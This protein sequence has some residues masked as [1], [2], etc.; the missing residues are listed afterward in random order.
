MLRTVQASV[1]QRI[2]TSIVV[3]ARVEADILDQE[4]E[5]L[6]AIDI[7]SSSSACHTRAGPAPTPGSG[8]APPDPPGGSTPTGRVADSRSRRSTS[9]SFASQSRSKRPPDQ[10]VLRVDRQEAAP[11]QLRLVARP[12]HDQLPLAV[13]PACLSAIW[14]MAAIE[15]SSCAGRIASRKAPATAAS[16]PSPRSDWQVFSPRFL[17]S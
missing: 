13:H 5:Q 7:A 2:D 10:A 3:S 4:S 12:L 6:F 9:A 11:G 15:T 8:H 1:C 17:W 16:M 14:S